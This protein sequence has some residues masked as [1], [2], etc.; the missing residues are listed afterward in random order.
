MAYAIDVP[1]S[2]WDSIHRQVT[3]K[4]YDSSRVEIRVGTPPP[5][6]QDRIIYLKRAEV[7]ALAGILDVL[8]AELE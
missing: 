3:V 1:A 5:T 2:D 4:K 7:K 6:R 8:A